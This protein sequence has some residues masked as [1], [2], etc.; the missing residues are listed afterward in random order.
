AQLSPKEEHDWLIRAARFA[1]DLSI[2]RTFFPPP[3]VKKYLVIGAAEARDTKTWR[4]DF[5]DRVRAILLDGRVFK[6]RPGLTLP[7]T[8]GEHRLEVLS[9]GEFPDSRVLPREQILRY[10]FPQR[11]IVTGACENPAPAPESRDVF[12]F[13][14]VDCIAHKTGDRWLNVLE[15]GRRGSPVAHELSL[16]SVPDIKPEKSSP[17]MWWAVAGLVAGG[18]LYY[19]NNR[20][21]ESG[22]VQPTHQTG[23]N[24]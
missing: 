23:T 16:P 13:F 14:S 9:N 4:P 19:E 7:L 15:T 2:D 11:A 5:L 1:P 22:A 17:W 20:G 21:R 12:A 18:Y 3:L 10:E 6:S 8:A 24:K